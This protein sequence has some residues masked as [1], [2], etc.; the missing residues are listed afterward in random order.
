MKLV[1]RN[2]AN[3]R[4]HPKSESERG[5]YVLRVAFSRVSRKMMCLTITP[6]PQKE[7]KKKEERRKRRKVKVNKKF[8]VKN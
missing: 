5:K 7:R 6:S 2:R 1:N 8:V 3:V 4:H